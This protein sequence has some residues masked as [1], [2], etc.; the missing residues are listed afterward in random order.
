MSS[1]KANKQMMLTFIEHDRPI[2]I[3]FE[4]ETYFNYSL[5]LFSASRITETY[6]EMCSQYQQFNNK[7]KKSSFKSI[8]DRLLQF[9]GK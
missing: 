5:R 9:P 8:D 2:N 4:N 7:N 3:V 6:S 1:I